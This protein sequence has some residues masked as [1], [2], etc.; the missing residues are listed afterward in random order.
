MPMASYAP[1]LANVH[2]IN[3]RPDLIY[4]DGT[5]SYGTPSYY[6][7]KMF[8]D[9][10]LDSVVPVQVN[11]A[12]MKVRT[13]GA[14]SA[15][16]Y[17]AQAEFQDEKITGSGDDYTYSVRAR[18][19]GGDGGLVIRFAKQDGWDLPGMVPRCAAS[20]QHASGLGRRRQPGCT[21]APVGNVFRGRAWP[22]HRRQYRYRPVVRRK[23][24]RTGP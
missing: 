6:V 24:P 9:S 1:L 13:D 19:T 22:C 4:F 15:E 17:D 18:K 7:Q 16:G 23:D 11:A 20:R 2:A 10:R 3:W 8:A 12:E 5:S 21:G 14:V